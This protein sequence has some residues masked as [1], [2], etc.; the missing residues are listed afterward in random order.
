MSK[1]LAEQLVDMNA[2]LDTIEAGIMLIAL[3]LVIRI[4]QGMK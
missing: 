2:T 4:V 1:V 3:M